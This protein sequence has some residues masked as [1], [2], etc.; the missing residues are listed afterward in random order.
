MKNMVTQLSR[1]GYFSVNYSNKIKRN[2]RMSV[3]RDK[4]CIDNTVYS[5][6]Q[7]FGHTFS[8]SGYFWIIFYIVDSFL[9]LRM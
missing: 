3:T 5:D 4:L 6:M 8:F 9:L 2:S 1:V 7:E